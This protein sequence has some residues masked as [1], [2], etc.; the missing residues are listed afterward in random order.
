MSEKYWKLLGA[1]ALIALGVLG[2]VALRPFV[3]AGNALIAFDLFAVIGG[4][5]FL[6]LAASG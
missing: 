5:N 3:P 1:V 4:A 6:Y 2:R